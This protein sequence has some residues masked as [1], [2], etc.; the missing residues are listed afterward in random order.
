MPDLSCITMK[1]S[2]NAS[3]THVEA[4]AGF[5]GVQ[6]PGHFIQFIQDQRVTAALLFRSVL[7]DCNVIWEWPLHPLRESVSQY[8]LTHF[9]CGW[10]HVRPSLI[11]CQLPPWCPFQWQ[12]SIS[13]GS[14]SAPEHILSGREML[15]L[16]VASNL[17]KLVGESFLMSQMS[18]NNDGHEQHP[19][20]CGHSSASQ[21]SCWLCSPHTVTLSARWLSLGLNQ[22]NRLHA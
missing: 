5:S 3:K 16:R 17:Q 22:G 12:E 10:L 14:V 9:L 19:S 21:G 6:L 20:S 1:R 13:T 7:A 4:C 15:V 8:Q 2:D 11:P 18:K